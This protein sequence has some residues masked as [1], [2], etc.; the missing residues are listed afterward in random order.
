[1]FTNTSHQ[2]HPKLFMHDVHVFFEIHC[3]C[4]SALLGVVQQTIINNN[5]QTK[6]F[7]QITVTKTTYN[8]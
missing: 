8:T 2:I 1:M 4:K 5:T 7:L 3:A 6:K